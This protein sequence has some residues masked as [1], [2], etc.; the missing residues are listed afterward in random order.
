M[1]GINMEFFGPYHSQSFY[2]NL[3]TCSEKSAYTT[4]T[5]FMEKKYISIYKYMRALMASAL[6]SAQVM[7][8]G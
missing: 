3:C 7:N 6:V 4:I 5:L 1:Y 2:F 8:V